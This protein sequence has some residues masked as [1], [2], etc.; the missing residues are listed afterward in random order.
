MSGIVELGHTGILVR[1]LETQRRFYRDVLG[2]TVTDEDEARGLVFLSSRPD[3]EHH[4]L[5]LQSGRTDDHASVVQ[6][7]S[8]RVGTIDALKLFLQTFRN[9]AVLIDRVITH[10]NAIGV[11]FFDPE[12]NR[13]EVYFQTGEDVPQPFAQPI[14]LLADD[15][16]LATSRRLVDSARAVTGDALG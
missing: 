2:L 11:Y 9:Q 7:I 4:E 16:V 8:W 12:G 3:V 15:D 1:D 6:Q 5:V 14:D 10:G 13:N